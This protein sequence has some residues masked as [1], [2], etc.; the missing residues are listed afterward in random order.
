MFFADVDALSFC[1]Q[2]SI[3]NIVR[4][5]TIVLQLRLYIEALILQLIMDI[6][7]KILGCSIPS[8]TYVNMYLLMVLLIL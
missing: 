6:Y 3:T 4:N 1:L 2:L 8:F 5:G 7:L